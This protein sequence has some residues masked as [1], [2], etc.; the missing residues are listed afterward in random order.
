MTDELDKI[1]EDVTK[2]LNLELA[3]LA[4]RNEWTNTRADAQRILNVLCEQPCRDIIS[5][6][7][8][9]M[10]DEVQMGRAEHVELV[11]LTE[12]NKRLRDVAEQLLRLVRDCEN[13]MRDDPRTHVE[14]GSLISVGTLRQDIVELGLKDDYGTFKHP[15]IDGDTTDVSHTTD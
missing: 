8:A 15:H 5:N 12:E 6:A 1:A 10:D 11:R 13:Y 9:D 14:E 2:K 7:F 3:P 4:M